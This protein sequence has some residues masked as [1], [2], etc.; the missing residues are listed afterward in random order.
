[1]IAP[2]DRRVIEREAVDAHEFA[3]GI[4]TRS[5]PVVLRG[6]VAAWPAVAA[7]RGGHR[8]LADYVARFAGGA[9]AETLVGPPE[10]GGRFFYRDDMRGLNFKRE[11][12][13][14]RRLMVELLRIADQS[15][16]PA[17]YANA[18]TADEHLPGWAEE[19][20]LAFDP[21]GPARL[22][23]GNATQVATHYD[24]SPNIACVVAGKRRFTL[25]PPDQIANLYIGPIDRTIAGPPASMVD[26]DA[27][28]L[29]RYPRFSDALKHAQV[30][31]LEPGDALFI[32]SLWWHHVRAFGAINVLVN[33]WRD[34]AEL[35]SPFVALVHAMMS[36]RDLPHAEKT[37]WRSWFDHY[38]FGANADRAAD[39]LP[40]FIRGVLG[41]PS[42]ER[43]KQL[44]AYV[45]GSLH[46]E[47]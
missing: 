29:T 22:W 21:G 38:V 31:E 18:A 24:R 7:G 47:G 2:T 5:A 35:P 9:P 19:N 36:V 41:P 11:Q 17:L 39:H 15:A 25:F 28:D 33:Y 30:A 12:I 23:V 40:D 10:I 45:M 37:A 26:P 46:Q 6:Q 32:P 20:R 4:A 1:M 42:A 3:E 43:T 16:P 14:L 27:P 8:A 13:P 34:D 44:R